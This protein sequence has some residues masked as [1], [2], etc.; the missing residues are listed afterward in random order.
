M[1]IYGIYECKYVYTIICICNNMYMQ[2]LHGEL[3][4]NILEPGNIPVMISLRKKSNKC[5]NIT[6]CPTFQNIR[7]IMK[8]LH[9]LLTP[10]KEHKKSFPKAFSNG[11]SLKDYLVRV[12][13]TKLND[14][15]HVG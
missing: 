14:V 3:N 4:I 5:F 8:K 15:N 10:N 7:I 11:K 6:Y 13:L 9:I 1:N 12:T 2:Y